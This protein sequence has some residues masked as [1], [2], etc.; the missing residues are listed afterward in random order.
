MIEVAWISE[1]FLFLLQ[2]EDCVICCSILLT[3]KFDYIIT[4]HEKSLRLT[5]FF[6]MLIPTKLCS[7]GKNTILRTKRIHYN[8]LTSKDSAK[9]KCFIEIKS[10]S[11]TMTWWM[12]NENLPV[13][14]LL[15]IVGVGSVGGGGLVCCL[16]S[17][18]SAGRAPRFRST[19]GSSGDAT[20]APPPS[21]AT[22]TSA[23]RAPA[24]WPP[25]ARQ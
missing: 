2:A 3:Q 20:A 4:G 18:V 25:G 5:S 21:A 24:V 9:L 14:L 6:C 15:S 23:P 1:I 10:G 22:T 17:A 7:I 11:E 8:Y 12:N 13:Y 16:S 19:A